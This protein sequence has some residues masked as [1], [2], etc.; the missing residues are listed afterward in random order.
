MLILVNVI[1]ILDKF[2]LNQIIL[3]INNLYINSD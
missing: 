2:Q 1:F 3:L